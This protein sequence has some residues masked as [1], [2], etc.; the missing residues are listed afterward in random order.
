MKNIYAMLLSSLF[1]CACTTRKP[2]APVVVEG[3]YF[4]NFENSKVQPKGSKE[5]WCIRGDMSQAELDDGWGR[6]DVVVE[7]FVGPREHER[8]TAGCDRILTLTRL[9]KVSKTHAEHP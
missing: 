9:I 1:L 2:A 8:T 5:W 3:E 7:G 4:Y 6:S